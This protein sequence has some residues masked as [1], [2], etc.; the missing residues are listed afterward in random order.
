MYSYPLEACG[1]EVIAAYDGENGLARARETQPDIIVLDVRLPDI[2]GWNVCA[3]LK[4]DPATARIPIVVLTAAADPA[5]AQ[6]A[7]EAGC[8]AHLLKPCYPDELTRTIFSL[9]AAA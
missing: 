4:S 8:A 2:T 6:Q 7:M 3:I 1:C 5:V 9:V